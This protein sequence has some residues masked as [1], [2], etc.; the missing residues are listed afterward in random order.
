VTYEEVGDAM[1]Y[2]YEMTEENRAAC[3]FEG[4][5]WALSNGLTAEQMGNKMIAMFQN[6]FMMHREQRP[7]FTVTSVTPKKY[8]QTGIVA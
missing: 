3:G 4:R 5:T 7:L 8:E 2:W 1:K 6:L